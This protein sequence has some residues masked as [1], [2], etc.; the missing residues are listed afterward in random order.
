M[1]TKRAHEGFLSIDH[2][3]SPGISIADSVTSGLP[4]GA[5]AG[6]FE[7]PTYTCSHCQY[8]VV[9]EPARTREREWC[10]YCDHYICDACGFVYGKTKTCTSFKALA[11]TLTEAA[12]AQLNIKEL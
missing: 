5:G 10:R 1:K 2:R 9:I 8:V 12:A 7:A 4:P 3:G 11:D 6:L